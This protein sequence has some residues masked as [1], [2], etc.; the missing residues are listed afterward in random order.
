V[1]DLTVVKLGGSHALSETLPAW[2]DAIVEGAGR[3]VLVAGGGPFADAVRAAQPVMGFDDLAADSM[4]LIAMEQYAIALASL[5]P[6]FAVVDSR[7]A[8]S[9]ALRA[10]QVPVWA[11]RRMVRDARDLPASWD[12]TSDSLAAWLAGRLQA[13]RLMLIK[14]CEIEG[15]G[16][17]ASELAKR[18]LV[19]LAFPGFLAASKVPGFLIGPSEH[20]QFAETM[21]DGARVGREIMLVG[22]G[23]STHHGGEARTSR[24]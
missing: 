12:V 20:A 23:A 3:V 9:A 4:A 24:D 16:L 18:G 14:R 17:T 13:R 1:K 15:G 8:I 6:C 22:E 7:T 19:D 2:L 10:G 21:R 11:P 5:R